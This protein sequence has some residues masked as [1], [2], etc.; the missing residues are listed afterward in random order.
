[1]LFAEYESSSCS[2]EENEEGKGGNVVSAM[3]MEDYDEGGSGA[4]RKGVESGACGAAPAAKRLKQEEI[5]P[6]L[7]SPSDVFNPGTSISVSLT[8]APRV[9]GPPPSVSLAHSRKA[10]PTRAVFLPPQLRRPNVTT[11]ATEMWNS[12]ALNAA[13]SRALGNGTRKS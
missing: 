10:A 2:E 6:A 13:R 5:V 9:S 12:D 4:K 11:E 8:S 1:M 7:P 3:V